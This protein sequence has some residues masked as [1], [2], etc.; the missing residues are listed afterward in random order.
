MTYTTDDYI[1]ARRKV[2]KEFAEG[3][4][5]EEISYPISLEIIRLRDEAG[6]TQTQL[7]NLIGTTQSVISRLEN[8]DTIPTVQTL[9][10]IANALGQVV[11]IQFIPKKTV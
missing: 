6:L 4:K 7:A 3:M 1:K 2:D 8:G 10:K 9:Y 11:N 5:K